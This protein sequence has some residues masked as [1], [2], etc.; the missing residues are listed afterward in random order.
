MHSPPPPPPPPHAPCER[1]RVGESEQRAGGSP[2]D[3]RHTYLSLAR[4][5][6]TEPADPVG[7]AAAVAAAVRVRGLGDEAAAVASGGALLLSGAGGGL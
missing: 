2:R 5:L 6:R 7:E 1:E 4:T 3:H